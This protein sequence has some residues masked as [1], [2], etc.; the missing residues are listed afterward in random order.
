M[1]SYMIV[2][3]AFLGN[4]GKSVL[5]FVW[6]LVFGVPDPCQLRFTDFY[7]DDLLPVMC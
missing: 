3:S 5:L 7:S 1:L 2:F 4:L 6:F